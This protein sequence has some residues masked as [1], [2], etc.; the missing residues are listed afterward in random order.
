MSDDARIEDDA[1][2]QLAL[3]AGPAALSSDPRLSLNWRANPV[4]Y[5]S[6]YKVTGMREV[7]AANQEIRGLESTTDKQFNA[8]SMNVIEL[9]TF[10]ITAA[11]TQ[12]LRE[13]TEFVQPSDYFRTYVPGGNSV[14]IDRA[15]GERW[16]SEDHFFSMGIFPTVL[17]ENTSRILYVRPYAVCYSSF[18]PSAKSVL[19]SLAFEPV[20]G[21]Y[22]EGNNTQPV[23]FVDMSLV[24][25][26]DS[27]QSIV[28]AI[29]SCRPRHKSY[30][31][32][33]PLDIASCTA[34]YDIIGYATMLSTGMFGNDI[35]PDQDPSSVIGL[36]ER[37]KPGYVLDKIGT[38]YQISG[39][40]LGMACVAAF[41]NF[42]RVAY[43]GFLR[44]L[45]PDYK[46]KF[47]LRP[48]QRQRPINH[49]QVM[50]A[51]VNNFV[52]TK[53]T[54]ALDSALMDLEGAS[55]SIGLNNLPHGVKQHNLSFY[56]GH[57]PVGGYPELEKTLMRVSRSGDI[58]EKVDML[59]FKCVWALKTGY[60]LVLP[61]WSEFDQPITSIMNTDQFKGSQFVL[62]TGPIAYSMS[63]AL[64]GIVY[65]DVASPLLLAVTSSQACELAAL[66]F[67]TYHTQSSPALRRTPVPIK[68][69][70]HGEA[71]VKADEAVAFKDV[72][73][74]Q[75][76]Y[77]NPERLWVKHADLAHRRQYAKQQTPRYRRYQDPGY[78]G[79]RARRGLSNIRQQQ[80][81]ADAVDEADQPP[82]DAVD[83]A[84]QP[85]ADAVDEADRPRAA[86]VP[87][88]RRRSNSER[89]YKWALQK[90]RQ[91]KRKAKER[92]RAHGYPKPRSS[93]MFRL[94]ARKSM[95]NAGRLVEDDL[96][97]VLRAKRNAKRNRSSQSSGSFRSSSRALTPSNLRKLY[98][99]H[100]SISEA[101]SSRYHTSTSRASSITASSVRTPSS[102]RRRTVVT[103]RPRRKSGKQLAS[104]KQDIVIKRHAAFGAV[105][106]RKKRGPK[107]AGPKKQPRGGGIV[108][109]RPSLYRGGEM[110]VAQRL[111]MWQRIRV[112][113]PEYGE[114][115][116][117]RV[118]SQTDSRT[119]DP[120]TGKWHLGNAKDEL[121]PVV[122]TA[123]EEPS[124]DKYLGYIRQYMHDREDI[125][126]A[127]SDVSEHLKELLPS[128][129]VIYNSLRSNSF[130]ADMIDRFQ[131]DDASNRGIAQL[132]Y[133]TS[134][135]YVRLGREERTQFI[136]DMLD[137]LNKLA[138]E[139]QDPNSTTTPEH[140]P[141]I[142]ELENLRE[143]PNFV[144]IAYNHMKMNPDAASYL[145]QMEPSD[146]N[147]IVRIVGEA[148]MRTPLKDRGAFLD[149]IDAHLR[150]IHFTSN[151]VDASRRTT[152]SPSKT[153]KQRTSPPTG[154]PSSVPTVVY[155]PR[156]PPEQLRPAPYQWPAP[157]PAIGTAPRNVIPRSYDFTRGG[158]YLAGARRPHLPPTPPI[159]IPPT[160]MP[161]FS[162]PDVFFPPDP[163][164]TSERIPDP[165]HALI[166]HS[167]YPLQGYGD[168]EGVVAPLPTSAYVPPVTSWLHID[169]F[170]SWKPQPA[171]KF[172]VVG[173]TLRARLPAQTQPLPKDF[174]K[175][176]PSDTSALVAA[177]QAKRRMLDAVLSDIASS[178][179]PDVPPPVP[180]YD[181]RP[182]QVH[183]PGTLVDEWGSP[184]QVPPKEAPKKTRSQGSI[185]ELQAMQQTH[186]R[187]SR[188]SR[189]P[190]TTEQ[191]TPMPAR[192]SG[193]I[194]TRSATPA[195]VS[196]AER[197]T[198]QEVT[199]TKRQE[200]PS[201]AANP[202]SDIGAA[203]SSG[204]FF[205]GLRKQRRMAGARY[206]VLKRA[207][208]DGR[209]T[210]SSR[211]ITFRRSR[212]AGSR[213]HQLMRVPTPAPPRMRR[214]SAVSTRSRSSHTTSRS[215]RDRTPRRVDDVLRSIS[216][217]RGK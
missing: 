93:Y 128:M 54:P 119:Y 64:Q 111:P 139:Q 23:V 168:G 80:P 124:M 71:L 188:R 77:S 179:M 16:D 133:D 36:I 150:D 126:P 104:K 115:P 146:R 21:Q 66:A 123:K 83:E 40:S 138:E 151:L 15:M 90:H 153:N 62:S 51:V 204:R 24:R 214:Y 157:P 185:A 79:G 173:R 41:C 112:A 152:A 162:L 148:Y 175:Y 176:Q 39:A 208:A 91:D 206:G 212:S 100:R 131:H 129:R 68:I 136:A 187:Y 84:D 69:T 4:N 12:I 109:G 59:S 32:F 96:D 166:D 192:R 211:R 209:R 29:N 215:G 61:Y 60:P 82:A 178:A 154:R 127:K 201:T 20:V 67:D 184:I 125:D 180:G 213:R 107:A 194:M 98:S 143:L 97:T 22:T 14:L 13:N 30:L 7:L 47:E 217:G 161:T 95:R 165:K 50:D 53:P 142:Q 155:P 48:G 72:D 6:K 63:Q 205:R 196:P 25:N 94:N 182:R 3:S 120:K 28:S 8:D 186:Q 202:G 121:L 31:W 216:R 46:A 132:L 57:S 117:E 169:P 38:Y 87:K 198:P 197:R 18:I 26:I 191:P 88:R 190:L 49:E 37:R 200:S 99:M 43:T 207:R 140:D 81:P 2:H 106:A 172:P 163:H 89:E 58:V 130:T 19:H 193:T 27:R 5:Q 199:R 159:E 108:Y 203:N 170:N 189:T 73:Y 76:P 55:N 11:S 167:K 158:K 134:S 144:W 9:P 141:D 52:M 147:K 122:H 135:R 78:R 42:P 103:T 17:V 145:A 56:T 177:Q 35:P 160:P 85:P 10:S 86:I 114:D 45:V 137:S 74:N 70:P 149:N 195:A 164:T 101:P 156:R 113:Q 34:G 105:G 75:R 65:N 118:W 102:A 116:T 110:M 33:M 171:G 174:E 92:A 1:M 210:R 181:Y 183:G 44:R